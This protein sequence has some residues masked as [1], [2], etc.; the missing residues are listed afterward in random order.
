MLAS[1]AVGVVFAEKVYGVMAW[2]I[3]VFVAMST[4]G[5]VNGILFTSSR[6]FFAGAREGQMP[7]ILTMLHMQRMTPVPAV[8]AVT[9][10]SLIYMFAGD[11]YQLITYV[12]VCVW[13]AIGVTVFVVLWLRWK[14]PNLYRPYRVFILCPI[15]YCFVTIYIIV[16]PMVGDPK[17][18]GTCT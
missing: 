2:V 10:L 4:F 11:V 9:L 8:V 13:L 15:I 17:E 16:L 6:L 1:L 18:T 12:S 7:K 3:P 5:G 14:A